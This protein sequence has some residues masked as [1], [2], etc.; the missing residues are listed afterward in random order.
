M[1]RERQLAAWMPDLALTLGVLTLAYVLIFFDGW[2][3]L[4][5]DSDTGWHI[6]TG[7]AILLKHALP[8]TDPYSFSREG[9]PWLDWEWASDVAT[10]GAHSAL[11]LSGVALLFAAS[12]AACSW[13]WIR[14]TWQVGGDFLIA[15]VLAAPMLSTASLHWLARPHIFGWVL[16]LIWMI[17]ME[18]GKGAAAAVAI[19]AVWANVHGSF[20]V[21]PVV[22]LLYA[23]GCALNTLLWPSDI[24]RRSTPRWYVKA[25]ILFTIGTL[26]NPYGIGLHRHV[27]AY[28]ADTELL[29]RIGEFQSFNFHVAGA[30]WILLTIGTAGLG[31]VLALGNR[32]IEHF[33]ISA[34]FIAAALRSARALPLVAL[35]VLPIANA[36][37]AAA[38]R[39]VDGVAPWLR[40]RIQN[41]LDYSGRLR[42]LDRGLA[43]WA[44][45]PIVLLAFLFLA[46]SAEAGFPS[47]QFPVASVDAVS[48]L[49][50][51]ARLLAPDKFAGYLIYQFN[52]ERKVFFDGRSDF[53]GAPFMKEYV[54]L[55]EVRPGWRETVA[56]YRFTHALL[57]NDYSMVA[58]LETDGWTLMHK[59][60]T[61]TL[62]AAPRQ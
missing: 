15:C 14:L 26:F 49:P 3:Q 1:T 37:L 56:R 25:A 18:R 44:V 50:A 52:G 28:L 62:L 45:A 7:E 54:R 33:L 23:A 39:K 58:A 11:G 34:F 4:F 47:D 61:A 5:R 41:G 53:Y 29:A 27:A 8:H 57:P 36:N 31:A 24:G 30:G 13:L 19:G 20:F 22:A 55:V 9:A 16:L 51:Q 6:R 59:D 32:R 42:D 21:A 35:C 46:S 40:R 38:L 12:I 17:W 60:A 48:K 43:G 10:G 2:H